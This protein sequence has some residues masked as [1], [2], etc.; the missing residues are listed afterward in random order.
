MWYWKQFLVVLEILT[1]PIFQGI[2]GNSSS[3]IP[4]SSGNISKT[5]NHRFEA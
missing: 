1:G 4:G 2:S 3:K 5:V